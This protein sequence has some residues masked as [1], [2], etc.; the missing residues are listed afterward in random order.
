MMD[1]VAQMIKLPDFFLASSNGLGGG[2]I[3]GTASESTLV[4]I[5]SAKNKAIGEFKNQ[6]PE[7]SE[8]DVRSKL[9]IYCSEQAHSS[10]ERAAMLA[11]VQ[12]KKLPM[13]EKY[14]LRGSTFQ[15]AI[16]K[17]LKAGIIP[18]LVS[19]KYFFPLAI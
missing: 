19:F 12:C 6:H 9:A 8:S 18:I 3:Q 10:V 15:E 5:L 4:A 1:W 14:S 2:I 16:E 7:W 11:S 17:D 13:D